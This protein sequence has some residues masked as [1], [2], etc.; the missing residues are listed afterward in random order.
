[1]YLENI[2]NPNDLKL[3]SINE[4]ESLSVEVRKKI[5]EVMATNGGHLG[6]NLGM[7]ELTI[8]LHKIF[9]ASKC[10]FIFDVSHQTYT[11]KLLSSRQDRFGKIRQE[12]GLSGFAHPKESTYDH[13]YSGH[14]GCALSQALGMHTTHQIQAIDEPVI[15]IIGDAALSCGLTLEALNHISKDKKGLIV[16]LNDNAMS[17]SHGVGTIHKDIL[18]QFCTPREQNGHAKQFFEQFCF[19][20]KGP[21]DGHNIA[22]IIKSLAEAQ[23]CPGPILIHVHTIKGYGLNQATLAP[24]DFH[25]V[26]P[27]DQKTCKFHP[28][29]SSSKTFPKVFGKHLHKLLK[30]NGPYCSHHTS[31]GKRL[32]YG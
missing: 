5:I 29:P 10:P 12:S 27:F 20:Y 7:V 28:T 16:I 3:L 4:L 18:G 21:I 8:A 24:V 1:M 11:H 6:S 9:D 17:I 23:K 2:F 31:H 13:F 32:L 22:A 19:T 25:G 15:A 30:D 26:K 14:A